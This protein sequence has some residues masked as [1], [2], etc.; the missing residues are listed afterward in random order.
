MSLEKDYVYLYQPGGNFHNPILR[1]RAPAYL[2]EISA[3]GELGLT[4]FGFLDHQDSGFADADYAALD[5]LKCSFRLFKQGASFSCTGTRYCYSSEHWYW[6]APSKFRIVEAG[7]CFNK[8]DMMDMLF[9]DEALLG[10]FEMS[11]LPDGFVLKF[12][13]YAKQKISGGVEFSLTFP[14]NWV[15][16]KGENGVYAC[17]GEHFL[18]ITAVNA[19]LSAEGNTIVFSNPN[20]ELSDSFCGIGARFL[21]DRRKEPECDV[22]IVSH[23]QDVI[24]LMRMPDYG[25]YQIE[26]EGNNDLDFNIPEHRNRCDRVVVAIE[27]PTDEEQSCMLCFAKEGEHFSVTG[28]SPLWRDLG[29]G[30]PNGI[31]VQ[32]TKDWHVHPDER[33]CSEWFAIPLSA[34]RRY[35][36]GKWSRLY[37]VIKLKPRSVFEGEFVC[38]YENWGTAPAV[39]HAQLSLV[40]WG[41]YDVWEQIAVGSHGE[42]ICF[43]AD[44]SSQGVSFIN[45]VRPLYT[46]GRHGGFRTYDWSENVGG[47]ELLVYCDRQGNRVEFT[48]VFRDFKAQCPVLSEAVYKLKTKDGK[49]EALLSINNVRTDDVLKV[50]FNIDYFFAEDTEYS[51]LALFQYDSERY[52]G[53]LFRKLAHGDG[54]RLLENLTFEEDRT[55]QNGY[56]SHYER[57]KAAGKAPWFYLYDSPEPRKGDVAGLEGNARFLAEGKNATILIVLRRYDAV[58]NGKQSQASYSIRQCFSTEVTHQAVEINPHLPEGKI[59][60]GSKV[61]MCVELVCLPSSL[62]RYYGTCAYLLE[63]GDKLDDPA[64]ALFQVTGDRL[65]VSMLEGQLKQNYPLVFECENDRC[66]FRL[67]GGLGY[68]PMRFENLSDYRG[69]SLFRNQKRVDQS[70]LG[71]DFWQTD[72]DS[73][74]GTYALSFSVPNEDPASVFELR[75]TE[76]GR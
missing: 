68:V 64:C 4:R 7:R 8:V 6:C 49:I 38:A 31:P 43:Q 57:C 24:R 45:D 72:Y 33:E 52:Q 42:N 21:L 35:L 51:R 15:L 53:N 59:S 25:I 56:N 40:G 50:F 63:G 58:I 30:E 3:E 66:A 28:M 60:A 75:K 46:S 54:D 44:T 29:T 36:E 70:V 55:L 71:N 14:G 9:E 62:E 47:G 23:N 18:W 26:M 41:G 73:A 76:G 48:D 37:S 11:A 16:K 22:K 2:A 5:Q 27:N 1:F 69:F 74:S 19:G 39:S 17:R 61:S 13:G 65:Q 20:M 12:D 34:P 32:I 67:T 10:R